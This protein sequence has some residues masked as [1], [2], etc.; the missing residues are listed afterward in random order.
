MKQILRTVSII[1]FK[2]VVL[3]FFLSSCNN[4]KK[5]IVDEV[6]LKD[7]NSVTGTIKQADSSGVKIMK[8][9]ESQVKIMWS[10]IDSIVGK[11][12]KTYWE[13]VNLGYYNVPYFSTFRNEAMAGRSLG[14]QFKYGKAVRGKFMQYIALTVVPAKPYSINRFGVG[15]QR[16]IKKA[17]YINAHG[18]FWGMEY[19]FMNAKRNNGLQMSLDP[20]GG[21]DH[22]LNDQL[23]LHGKFALQFNVANKN[24]SAGVNLTVGITFLNRNFK[25]HYKTLNKQHRLLPD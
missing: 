4:H 1:P 18:F 14:L 2:I 19:N 24:N 20:F 13:G 15:F 10:D 5:L 12:Y 9:D 8:M 7:Q 17:A 23:R 21:Y 25:Q 22:K 11:R 6:I 16:Y 3:F